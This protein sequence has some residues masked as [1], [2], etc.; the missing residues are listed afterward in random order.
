MQNSGS[1]DLDTC[2]VP[3][4]MLK[5]LLGA[6]LTAVKDVA[7]TLPDEQRA[8]LA[9][10]CYRRAHFRDLGLSLAAQC[11]RSAL[12]MEAGH[13]GELIYVQATAQT[14]KNADT[15]LRSRGGK[16]PVSLHVV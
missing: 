7:A 13:A 1:T 15:G 11:S 16:P 5:R 3:E 10:Y 6:T 12:M 9:V 8:S 2:P 14:S 4:N